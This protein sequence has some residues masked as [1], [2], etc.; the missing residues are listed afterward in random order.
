VR[1]KTRLKQSQACFPVGQKRKRARAEGPLANIPNPPRSRFTYLS[2]KILIGSRTTRVHGRKPPR[3][4]AAQ[5][6]AAM[7]SPLSDATAVAPPFSREYED[8]GEAETRR[9]WARLAASLRAAFPPRRAPP[10]PAAAA[11]PTSGYLTLI[12]LSDARLQPRDTRL[13]AA[14]LLAFALLVAG[15]VFVAVPRGVSVGEVAVATDRMSW[16]TTKGTYQ[17]R[18]AVALPLFNPNY[19]PASVEGDLKVL[20]YDT[21][22]GRAEVRPV[23][24]GPRSAPKVRP[25]VWDGFR[26]AEA[27]GSG[28]GRAGGEEGGWGRGAGCP[29]FVPGGARRSCV[30]ACFARPPGI[31][32]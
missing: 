18:L 8:D 29:P 3:D 1:A 10:R 28:G 32:A 19:L 4:L 16:N 22:A 27:W 24:L 21:V 13:T 20:F 5:Q 31:E 14:F 23:R 2:K 12:P 9:P 25:C 11:S 15:A 17:L 6:F 30:H 7:G 26:V